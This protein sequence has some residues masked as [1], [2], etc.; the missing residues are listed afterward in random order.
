[1]ID[2]QVENPVAQSRRQRHY[3]LWAIRV[4]F[5]LL[6]LSIPLLSLYQQKE[7]RSGNFLSI[8]APVS[9]GVVLFAIALIIDLATP[10]KKLAT[11]FGVFVGLVLGLIATFA[12]TFLL[13]F[14]ISVWIGSDSG[15][16]EAFKPF[17]SMLEIMLG[18]GLCYLGITTVLQTQDD[19]R[20]V[21]P[22]VEFAKQI[23]GVK[24]TILDTSAII[25]ARI[26]DI[27]ATGL[28][29][30][31]LI[32]PKFVLG[33]LQV[34]AD[35]S[36]KL[37]RARGRRG[38]DVVTRLQRLGTIGVNI[39][40]TPVPESSVDQKLVEL[41][42]MLSARLM[43]TDLGLARVAQIHGLS[44]LNLHEISHAFKPAL[45]PG[46]E[47][48]LR[49]AKPGEQPGQGV[50]YL[51]DGTMVVAEGGAAHIGRE[52]RVL[53]T[54]TMQTTAGRLIFTR[55]PDEAGLLGPANAELAPSE[56]TRSESGTVARQ[57]EPGAPG[58]TEAGQ[59]Q[60]VDAD[61]PD[62]A[63]ATQDEARRPGPFPPKPQSRRAGTPRNPRR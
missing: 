30:G 8:T 6:M 19:F 10:N 32:I 45:I 47:M 46:E 15:I 13:R 11:I 62:S 41:A 61:E 18:V 51:E 36:D 16:T 43:T 33:E 3:L 35:S 31:T 54:S 53:V 52:V 5:L 40:E 9:V 28:M 38:L 17:A 14:L 42:R 44:V 2:E 26:V 12:F 57:A 59:R 56:A 1:M 20:L 4:I 25:D 49:I 24:P 34:L 58:F 60:D 29:Q 7:A 22:Y 63:R 50:G 21:I 39:D 27:G 23:R 48:L 55:I 37:K